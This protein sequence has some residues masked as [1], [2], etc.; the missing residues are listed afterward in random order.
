MLKELDARLAGVDAR[1]TLKIERWQRP[2]PAK[3][4]L[5]IG[6]RA[7]PYDA[8]RVNAFIAAAPDLISF[9]VLAA[10]P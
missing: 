1:L 3:E 4:G 2:D 6:Y 10:K 8:K 5:I 7:E 9:D